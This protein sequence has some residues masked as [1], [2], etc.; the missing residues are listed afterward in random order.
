MSR[1]GKKPISIPEGVIIDINKERVEVKGKNATL[2]VPML[3]YIKV[4]QVENEIIVTQNEKNKQANS[5]WGT[6]RAHINNAVL[7]ATEDF[8]KNLIVEGVGYKANIEGK[9][10]VLSLGFSHPI[11][12]PVSEGLKI[13][14]EK[15]KISI[16][17]ADKSAV[18]EA[19]AK[20]RSYRKPEP[21]KGK[22]IRYDDEIVK[23]KPGK[24][25]VGT[26]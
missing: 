1:I 8:V 23:R 17:G 6:M 13:E 22:G 5:N 3:A 14:A 19:A 12:F 20:I 25:A 18:G 24:K 7:G 9:D 11:K 21:Y 4:E 15:N 10:L 2:S 16:S 26:T